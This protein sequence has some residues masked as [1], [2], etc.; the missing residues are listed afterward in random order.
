MTI[1]L[2]FPTVSCVCAAAERSDSRVPFVPPAPK[3]SAN[4][5]FWFCPHCG[6]GWEQYNVAEHLWRRQATLDMF[7][8][9]W[10]SARS[11]PFDYGYQYQ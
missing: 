8:V 5:F 1:L 7:D 10:R 6:Q 11:H 2:V 3:Y 4:S 9:M